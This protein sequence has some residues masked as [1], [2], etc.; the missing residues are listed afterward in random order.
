MEGITNY[1]ESLVLSCIYHKLRGLPAAHDDEYIADVA[2]VALNQLPSR[3]VR[4]IVDT[5]FFESEEDIIKNNAAVAAAVDFAILFIDSRA[6]RRPDG[7]L[8]VLRPQ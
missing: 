3:Y 8:G 5:R 6:G 1:Y 7:S 4:Y 2:C